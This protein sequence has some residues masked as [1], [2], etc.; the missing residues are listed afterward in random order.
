MS[1]RCYADVFFGNPKKDQICGTKRGN[2]I[3]PAPEGCCPGG[4]PGQTKDVEPREPYGT[5]KMYNIRFFTRL[6]IVSIVLGLILL[7]Y[8]KMLR[9]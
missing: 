3:I 2:L 4:C 8:L 1:C 7:I 6:S 9:P 5:G